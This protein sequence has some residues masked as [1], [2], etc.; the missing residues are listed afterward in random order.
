MEYM[1]TTFTGIR[2]TSY[3]IEK[4]NFN[5]NN[6][7]RYLNTQLKDD[8][9]GNDLTEYRN[10]INT[11]KEFKNPF[12][13]N[14]IN[15]ACTENNKGYNSFK[16]NGITIPEEDKYIPLFSYIA[17]FTKK[18]ANTPE[19]IFAN[20]SKYLTSNY[21]DYALLLD[22]RLSDNLRTDKMEYIEKTHSPKNIKICANKINKCIQNTMVNYFA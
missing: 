15:I 2:N 3:I 11:Y 14:F 19:N 22:R 1:N 9:N 18:I 10:I 12:Y 17:K 16:L 4:D 13:S 7:T 8:E 21:L 20:D 6:K 5:K